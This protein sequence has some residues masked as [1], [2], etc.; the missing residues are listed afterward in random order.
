MTL[1]AG[2]PLKKVVLVSGWAMSADILSPLKISLE[3]MGHDVTAVS[4]ADA[5]GESWG[6]LFTLVAEAIGESSAVLAGWSLGG[7]VSARFAASY[8]DKVRGVV[9]MGST[10]CFLATEEWPAGKHPDASRVFADAVAE[11]IQNVMKG[12]APVCA[13]GSRDM[14]S[15]I[16]AFRTSSKWAF[17]TDTDWRELLNRLEEDARAD[18]QKVI[19]PAHHILADS[20]PLAKPE[21]A[22]HLRDLLPGHQVSV[23]PGCHGIFLDH[24]EKVASIIHSM[25]REDG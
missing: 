21:L 7:N 6:D 5:S 22:L 4:L 10:P 11:N 23:L 8:P 13:R 3:Q 18:W 20:D 9:T 1:A 14:K 19:C 25:D 2:N 12:F 17:A 16:R 15:A 24:P